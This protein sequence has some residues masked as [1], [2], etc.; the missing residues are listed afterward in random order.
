M[1]PYR[2][3]VFATDFSE[4]ADRIAVSVAQ[5]ATKLD[6][7]VSLVHVVGLVLSPGAMVPGYDPGL[8]KQLVSDADAALDRLRREELVGVESRAFSLVG[9]SPAA[10]IVDFLAEH[11]ADLCVVGTHGRTGMSRALIG[12]VAE[13]VVRHAP[14]DVLALRLDPD[15][16]TLSLRRMVCATDFSEHAE[17]ALMVAG[18]LARLSGS[19]LRLLHVVKPERPFFDLDGAVVVDPA[20][21]TRRAWDELSD[22]RSAKLADNPNV[23]TDT[24]IDDSPA[25]SIAAYAERHRAG[26]I[27][28]GTEGRTGLRRAWIGSVAERVVRHASCAVLVVRPPVKA[29]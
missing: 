3:I 12:S 10:S 26:L 16:P 25:V 5:L 11:A 21:I 17:R 1:K 23:L 18:G 20:E 14:C 27:V 8:V 19:E 29:A 13:R 24:L 4:G 6:A 2:H 22:L 9:G 7:K 15:Q 28:V